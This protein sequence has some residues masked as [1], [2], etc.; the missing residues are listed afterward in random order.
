[1]FIADIVL[2]PELGHAK[3]AVISRVKANS[4]YPK[5]VFAQRVACLADD[6]F[7]VFG[8]AGTNM[9]AAAKNH[10]DDQRLTAV[11]S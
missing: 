8:C 1:M 6:F 5:T 11:F 9:M 10:A 3:R 7:K 4:D 2:V